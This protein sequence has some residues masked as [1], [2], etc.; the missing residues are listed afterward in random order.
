[1]TADLQI[2]QILFWCLV[3][4]PSVIVLGGVVYI[5][6][7]VMPVILRQMQQL[8]DNN[9]QFAKIAKDNADGL[10]NVTSEI[11]R[12]TTAIETQTNE[13]KTQGFDFKSY[14]TLLSDGMHDHSQQIE[15]NTT[16]I[17]ILRTG[18]EN[19]PQLI[20]LAIKDEMKCGELLVEFGL[21]RNEVTRAVFQQQARDT[22][23]FRAVPTP[24]APALPVPPAP[25]SIPD[26]TK[27]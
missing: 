15:A 19:M 17:S 7:R 13:I 23:T 8:V 14:Q 11:Q 6:A 12:Q 16:A 25:S 20:I 3:G 10:G 26:E 5:A 18:L 1:M 24:P 9:T 22:G 4:I 27:A 2:T 21:L